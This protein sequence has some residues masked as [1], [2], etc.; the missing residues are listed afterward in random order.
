[1][2]VRIEREPALRARALASTHGVP[3]ERIDAAATELEASDLVEPTRSGDSGARVLTA[4]GRRV[5]DRLLEARRAHL[6]ELIAEWNPRE[7]DAA[8]FLRYAV[9][10]IVPDTRSGPALV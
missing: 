3:A 4:A 1:L 5:L 2:L 8:S 9:R 10:E 7:E 6:R